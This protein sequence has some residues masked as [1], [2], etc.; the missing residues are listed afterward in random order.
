[1]KLLVW[2]LF[3]ASLVARGAVIGWFLILLGAI[4][5][6]LR[7]GMLWVALRFC[8]KASSGADWALLLASVLLALASAVFTIDF[9][10]VD[11]YTLFGRVRN[12]A[13][14]YWSLY[15]ILAAL[16]VLGHLVMLW[17]LWRG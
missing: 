1:M 6:P 14:W 12:P 13:S 15:L 8:D 9:S 10:D 3:L 11:S 4:E 7:A 16:A 5:L 2:I 17:R